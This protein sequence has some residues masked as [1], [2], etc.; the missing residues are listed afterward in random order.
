METAKVFNN[1]GSQAVRLPK[2]C[3][4]DQADVYVK[5]IGS[6]V[7][8]IPKNLDKRSWWNSFIMAPEDFMNERNQP[9]H[10]VREAL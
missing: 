7:I 10:Q 6:I 3:R 1:G 2:E 8:L 4:F 5:K 9:S